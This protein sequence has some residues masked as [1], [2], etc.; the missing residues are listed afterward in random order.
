MLLLAGIAA[1]T[2][3]VQ[4]HRCAGTGLIA[5]W[6]VQQVGACQSARE[7]R[8]VDA[9]PWWYR[10][11]RPTRRLKTGVF[12]SRMLIAAAPPAVRNQVRKTRKATGHASGMSGTTHCNRA[13]RMKTCT[14]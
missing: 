12:M 6:D 11:R 8:L 13:V 2:M 7:E 1:V 9:L 10:H 4:D 5:S 14:R 3:K